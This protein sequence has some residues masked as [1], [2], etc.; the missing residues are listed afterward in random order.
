MDSSVKIFGKLEYDK[1]N[2]LQHQKTKFGWKIY[3][4]LLLYMNRSITKKF[5]TETILETI[6]SSVKNHEKVEYDKQNWLQHQKI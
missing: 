4:F 6:N 1:Q 2:W 3:L 5:P